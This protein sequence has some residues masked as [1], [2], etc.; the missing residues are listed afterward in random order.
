MY[1]NEACFELKHV[2]FA[3]LEEE[4]FKTQFE[5]HTEETDND[6]IWETR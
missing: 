5:P 4:N 2:N 1:L 6:D 3:C